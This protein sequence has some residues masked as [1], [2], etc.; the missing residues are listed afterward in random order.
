MLLFALGV[1]TGT[2]HRQSDLKAVKK[3]SGKKLLGGFEGSAIILLGVLEIADQ[4][5]TD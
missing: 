4:W 5:M 3:H 2:R 1:G